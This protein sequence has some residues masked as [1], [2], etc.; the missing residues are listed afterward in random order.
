[1]FWKA[2]CDVHLV[3]IVIIFTYLLKEIL[4][5]IYQVKPKLSHKQKKL[6][7]EEEKW[8]LIFPP[9]SR[10]PSVAQLV[11]NPPTMQENW[12]L[13]L[14]WEHSLEQGK[15]TH[16]STVAY[17]LQYS[18]LENSMDCIVHGVTKSRTQRSNFHSHL[19]PFLHFSLVVVNFLSSGHR[20][21]SIF[22][23]ND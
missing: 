9:L 3:H 8:G 14:G 12:V 7:L 4:K 20:Y 16:S 2:L 17:P 15:A 18:R 23:S 21:D 19:H 10:L 22:L 13:S 11:K 1:M 6:L 5:I